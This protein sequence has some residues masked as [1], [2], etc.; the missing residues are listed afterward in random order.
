MEREA[1][2]DSEHTRL[3]GQYVSDEAKRVRD[4]IGTQEGVVR[5]TTF[6]EYRVVTKNVMRVAKEAHNTE[7]EMRPTPHHKKSEELTRMIQKS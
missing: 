7:R 6:G 3:N 1:P 5:I 4:F 2:D